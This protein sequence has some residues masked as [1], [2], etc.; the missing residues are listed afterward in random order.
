MNDNPFDH[1]AVGF[2]VGKG[3]FGDVYKANSR[4]T[5]E[6]VAIKV[7]DMED[8]NDQ[9]DVIR[10]EIQF[11]SELRSDYTTAYRETF[12]VGT[13]LWLVME[14]CGGGSC[15]DLLKCHKRLSEDAAAFIIRDTLRGLDYL[16]S[17]GIIHR[18][19]KAANL[20]LT[21]NGNVKVADFGVS[22]Q[23]GLNADS[24]RTFVGT[25][26]WMAPEII[27]QHSEDSGYTDKVDIW[28]VGITTIELVQGKPPYSDE[29][30][31]KALVQIPN[32]APPVLTGPGHGHSISTFIKACL[33]KNPK[34]RPSASEMLQ[35]Y[36]FVK[37]TRRQSPL[38]ALIASKQQWM[39]E[40]RA[41]HKMRRPLPV[42]LGTA[43]IGENVQWDFSECD[44]NPKSGI[45]PLS[46]DDTDL[47]PESTNT[48]HTSPLES[49]KV[50]FYED[51]MRFALDRVNR[52]AK[53]RNGKD[54]CT[55]L[56]NKLG[57]FER[58]QAG[59]CEAI[60]QEIYR[61]L[62]SIGYQF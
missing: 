6:L 7:V 34:K 23:L 25:P 8:S 58:E 31:M 9:I 47:R 38:P 39:N 18:D 16:H 19:I 45:S 3:N 55:Y 60:A 61:R 20:L 42:P 32:R 49:P 40:S 24:R 44:Q 27:L 46:T 21:D 1:Y 28:S 17:N 13:C 26:F 15:A 30:P 11:L 29:D 57:T 41:A 35:K 36:R 37:N 53:N 43:V 10:Q 33:V 54:F 14:F 59:L 2:R 62:R 56:A 12:V 5:N 50:D 48:P 22:G 4:T 51:V 52:R